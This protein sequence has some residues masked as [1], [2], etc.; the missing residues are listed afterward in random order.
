MCGSCGSLI[1]R[2]TLFLST[3]ILRKMF[4]EQRGSRRCKIVYLCLQIAKRD[5]KYQQALISCFK[6]ALGAESCY[7]VVIFQLLTTGSVSH[8]LLYKITG[9]ILYIY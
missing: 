3:R 2:E 5:G 8:N 7:Y 1:Q 9:V 6:V 4:T